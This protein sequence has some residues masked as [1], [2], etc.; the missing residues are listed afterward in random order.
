[1]TETFIIGDGIGE[2]KAGNYLQDSLFGRKKIEYI[3]RNQQPT[4]DYTQTMEDKRLNFAQ[5]TST[6]ETIIV[7]YN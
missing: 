5:S 2:Y 4:Y 6:G 7:H 3:L 1:M